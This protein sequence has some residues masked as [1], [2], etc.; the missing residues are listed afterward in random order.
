MA[1][2]T[3]SGARLAIGKESVWGTPVADT[4]LINY[5]SESL[6]P[7]VKKTE[8][9]SLLAAKAAAG[10]D[11]MG[12]NV[13][14][15]FSGILKPENA[16]FIIKA[17]LGGTDTNVPNHGGV[18]GQTQHTI[19]G[20][21]ANGVFPSYTLIVDRKAA[22]KR[23]S[24]CKV[25]NLKIT[26]KSGDYVRFT[27][28]VKGKDESTGTIATAVPPTKKAY[29][30]I[31]ATLNLG[32]SAMEIT[33]VE[34]D[35]QNQMDDGVQTNVTGVYM[36]EPLHAQRK[37]GLTIEVPYDAASEAIRTTNFLTEA[38]LATAVLHLESPEIITAASKFR[39]DITLANV[40]ILEAKVN[41]GG[42]GVIMMSI[43]AEAT[44]VGATEPISAVIYDNVATA[45]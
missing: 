13:A 15:D 12:I 22:I 37:I 33:S 45:Y 19:I 32:A 44:A 21:A 4:M 11:L 5:G 31:G 7:A 30:M 23:Y 10:Y 25:D 27:V 28:T 39:A 43:K 41:I 8:E 17:A 38:V 18:T 3:G 40:A 26:A 29:K 36:S 9:E 14:G 20:A 6:A 24:G 16:G 2:N 1:F 35:Y 34:L 42:P